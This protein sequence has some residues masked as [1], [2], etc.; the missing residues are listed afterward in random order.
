MNGMTTT[1]QLRCYYGRIF[2]LGVFLTSSG[3]KPTRHSAATSS[4]LRAVH[5]KEENH[6]IFS[7]TLEMASLPTRITGS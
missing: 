4:V 7:R 1:G 6:V 5:S 2:K 3:P